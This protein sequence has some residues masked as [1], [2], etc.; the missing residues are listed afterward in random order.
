VVALNVL[1]HL[2]KEEGFSLMEEMERCARQKVII[3]TPNGPQY[4]EAYD[5]NPLQKHQSSWLVKDFAIRGYSIKGIGGLAILK[6]RMRGGPLIRSSLFLAIILDITRELTYFFPKLDY[7][8]L[9]IKEVN[10]N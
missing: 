7:Q 4:Q 6:M 1:E 5:E 10:V 2:K 8:L 3:S 9:C